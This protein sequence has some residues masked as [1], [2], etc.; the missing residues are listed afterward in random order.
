MTSLTHM[1]KT[2]PCH[3]QEEHWKLFISVI[4]NEWKQV[5]DF[6]MFPNS[7]SKKT[8]VKETSEGNK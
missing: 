2:P 3:L 5:V 6:N 4:I 7:T 1:K 8:L